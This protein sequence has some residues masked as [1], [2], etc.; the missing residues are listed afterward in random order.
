MYLSKADKTW[1]IKKRPAHLFAVVWTPII[2]DNVQKESRLMLGSDRTSP[3]AWVTTPDSTSSRWTKRVFSF[4][5]TFLFILMYLSFHFSFSFFFCPFFVLFYLP[6]FHFRFL[7]VLFNLLLLFSSK[8]VTEKD[9]GRE[10]SYDPT[11]TYFC[12][13]ALVFICLIFFIFISLIGDIFFYLPYFLFLIVWSRIFSFIC[14]VFYFCL[15]RDTVG[16]VRR[17]DLWSTHLRSKATSPSSKAGTSPSSETR[18]Q[19]QPAS[20]QNASAT[21]AKRS[22][23]SD[24]CFSQI[25]PSFSFVQGEEL[26]E[27]V[28]EAER[29]SAG[30]CSRSLAAK[31]ERK[32]TEV[33]MEAIV[34]SSKIKIVS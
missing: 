4:H 27:K 14:L 3:A 9:L 8:Q 29:P 21:Q 11:P 15:I 23:W 5:F 19:P 28:E 26:R 24:K 31:E 22:G 6:F 33:N 18:S 12:K 25:L 32:E 1:T 7:F 13:L 34:L 30:L 2:S 10:K 16:T 20:S 17:A